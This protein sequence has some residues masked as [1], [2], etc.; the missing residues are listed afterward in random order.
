MNT[1]LGDCVNETSHLNQI[2]RQVLRG[3]AIEERES[4]CECRQR[5]T[6]QW[7]DAAHAAPRGLG[8]HF[9]VI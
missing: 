4:R 1:V 9:F 2:R 7:T 6:H 5:H 3:I 8:A